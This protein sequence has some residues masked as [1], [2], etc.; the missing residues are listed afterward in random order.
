M[1]CVKE[2][3]VPTQRTTNPVSTDRVSGCAE[4][5]FFA[6]LLEVQNDKFQ[7]N[8]VL[9]N[10]GVLPNNGCD[11]LNSQSCIEQLQK[12]IDFNKIIIRNLKKDCQ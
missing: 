9:I 10:F 12:K 11:R 3:I 2:N 4:N 1:S 6:S 7:E 8:I 5:L